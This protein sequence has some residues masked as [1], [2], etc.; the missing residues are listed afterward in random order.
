VEVDSAPGTGSGEGKD[1]RR[2]PR[3]ALLALLEVRWRD[4]SGSLIKETAYAREVNAHGG[5]LQMTTYPNPGQVL[6]ISNPGSGDS[7]QARAVALR[8]TPEGD[9]LGM[10]VELVAPSDTFWGITFRIKKASNDLVKL[11]E[12][13]RAGGLDQRVLRDFRDAVDYVRKTAWVVYEWQERQIRHR[14]TATVLPLLTAERIRR[15]TQLAKSIVADL[16]S[17]EVRPDTAGLTEFLQAIQQIQ[18]RL[19][20]IPN[21]DAND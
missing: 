19:A 18:E 5:L 2:S 4:S 3:F 7:T 8:A 1:L 21:P 13:L 14:D 20:G 15:A 17:H 16:E 10:G 12:A 11:E 9:V 6:E